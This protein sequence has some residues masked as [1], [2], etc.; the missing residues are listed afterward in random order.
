MF[1]NSSTGLKI[2]LAN[3]KNKQET[4]VFFKDSEL[5]QEQFFVKCGLHP[6]KV[7]DNLGTPLS[8][9]FGQTY[10]DLGQVE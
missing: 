3:L 1:C 9:F 5:K 10:S 2:S 4:E 8:V 6:N 7:N